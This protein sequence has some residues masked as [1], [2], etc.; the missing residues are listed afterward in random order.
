MDR[1]PCTRTRRERQRDGDSGPAHS[2]CTAEPDGTSHVTHLGGPPPLPQGR[3][4]LDVPGV[5]VGAAEPHAERTR[6][7]RLGAARVRTRVPATVATQHLPRLPWRAPDGGAASTVRAPVTRAGTQFA[8][9]S[10]RAATRPNRWYRSERYPTIASS[11]LTA[12]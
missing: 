3:T 2:D 4:V 6:C 5:H 7:R 9:S 8:T 1:D 12:R 11:V 10:R